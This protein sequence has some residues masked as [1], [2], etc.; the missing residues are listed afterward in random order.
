MAMQEGLRQLDG[1]NQ[2]KVHGRTSRTQF[3]IPLFWTASGVEANVTGSELWVELE[4]DYAQYEPWISILLNSEPISRLMIP[5]GRQWVCLFR[6]MNPETIKNVRIVK[7]VQAMSGDPDASLIVHGLKGNGELKP[8]EDRPFKLEFIGDSIT[9]GEGSIGAKPEEDWIPAWFSGVLNY[10]TLTAVALNADHRVLSQSGWGVM[11]SWDNNPNANL[12]AG[13]EQVCGLL[14]GDKNAALGAHEPNDFAAWQPDVVVINLGTNDG[15]AFYNQEWKDPNTGKVHK[16]RLNEDGS[17]HPEDL[18]SFEQAVQA[19]LIKLRKN[20]PK[21]DLVWA[22]GMLGLPMMPAI[23][24]A[25]DTYIRQTGDRK[26]SVFQLPNTNEHTIGARMH[27]GRL[28]HEAAAKELSGYL[29]ELL[30]A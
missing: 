28:A 24:R 12:P 29:K 7:D 18:A 9:S 21:A 25:V 8:V 3:P 6:G 10:T 30:K 1:A 13:Y 27:P 17:F 15:G 5:K 4:S 20:N 16:Q 14:T 2:V 26:V 22:Y 23:Y 19:F 11:T